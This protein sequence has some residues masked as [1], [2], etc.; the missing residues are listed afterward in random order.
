MA[1]ARIVEVITGHRHRPVGE[2]T[3]E[4]RV[5]GEPLASS[6]LHAN[7]YSLVRRVFGRAGW[8]YERYVEE[9]GRTLGEEL[10]EP[11]RI[12]AGDALDLQQAHGAPPT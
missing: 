11:T 10:L 4:P 2:D 1:S 6:G 8:G 7:G 12:Y 3:H 5:D 9:L